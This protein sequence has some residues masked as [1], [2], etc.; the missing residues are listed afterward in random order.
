MCLVDDDRV[1][2][3]EQPIAVHLVEQDAVGHQSDL[4]LC[5][6]LI[7]EA[8]LVPDDAAERHLHLLGDALRDRAG[9]E[10]ARLR[11]RNRGAAE[12]EGDLRQLRGLSAACGAGDDD[13]LVGTDGLGD[14]VARGADRQLRG[15][16]DD[17]RGGGHSPPVYSG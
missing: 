4:R 11:V 1:V 7:G 5:G 17:G 2:A 6:D 8:H 16:G 12:L 14:L 9:C 3:A 13:D 10:A 15:I